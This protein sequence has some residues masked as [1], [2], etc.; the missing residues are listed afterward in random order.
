MKHVKKECDKGNAHSDEYCSICDGGLF[1]CEICGC[2]EGE[3]TTD[4]SGYPV[5]HHKRDGIVSGKIDYIDG[6]GWIP[7]K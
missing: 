5:L 1:T 3:L 7:L 4:C 6:Y 2:S